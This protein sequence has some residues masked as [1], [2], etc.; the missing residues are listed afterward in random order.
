MAQCFNVFLRPQVVPC[1]RELSRRLQPW[2]EGPS[3]P[4]I[5]IQSKT[6]VLEQSSNAAVG[7]YKCWLRWRVVATSEGGSNRGRKGGRN[8]MVSVSVRVAASAGGVSRTRAEVAVFRG[9]KQDDAHGV[10]EARHAERAV[11]PRPW[12]Q[13]VH[14]ESC[15]G[16]VCDRGRV[17]CVYDKG[18]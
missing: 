7:E 14:A 15:D 10:V 2:R 18:S 8:R 3:M 1:V 9:A 13:H 4:I 6:R 12:F 5:W 16:W 17:Y 11:Q